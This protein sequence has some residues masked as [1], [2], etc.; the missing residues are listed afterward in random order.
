MIACP[1]IVNFIWNQFVAIH[2]SSFRYE[3]ISH[4]S[5]HQWQTWSHNSY[6]KLEAN[7]FTATDS[8]LLSLIQSLDICLAANIFRS[9]GLAM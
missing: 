6:F 9:I 2:V 1:M 7:I 4:Q 3:M 8:Q 5:G